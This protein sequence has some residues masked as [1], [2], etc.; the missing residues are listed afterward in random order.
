MPFV[1]VEFKVPTTLETQEFRLRMLTVHDVVKD[2]EA[3]MSSATHLKTVFPGGSW[4]D[5]LSL[6]QNLIDLGWHQKEFQTRRSF[7]YTVLNPS[8]SQVIGCVYINP[9]RKRGFDAEVFLWARQSELANGMESRLHHAVRT[10]IARE[11]P[12]KM[13]AFPCREISWEQW[14]TLPTDE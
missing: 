5:G 8:E 2:Y 13:V 9:S 14:Q 6:E 1:P 7:A 10:W 11:W 3:V 4:P 12:F